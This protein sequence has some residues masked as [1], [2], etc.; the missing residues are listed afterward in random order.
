LA[1]I[2]ITSGLSSGLSFTLAL[3][4]PEKVNKLEQQL[5]TTNAELERIYAALE[6]LPNL[7]RLEEIADNLQKL[8]GILSCLADANCT[9]ASGSV[10]GSGVPEYVS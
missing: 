1:R 2:K 4:V 8:T 5:T 3:L 6:K 9:V 10:Y 7:E